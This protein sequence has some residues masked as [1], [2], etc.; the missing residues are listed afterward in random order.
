MAAIDVRGWATEQHEL[1]AMLRPAFLLLGSQVVGAV[2]A[3]SLA[4]AELAAL[5]SFAAYLDMRLIARGVDDAA[6]ANALTTAGLQHGSGT[7]MSP[8]LVL[9]GKSAAPGDMVAGPSWFRQHEPRRLAARDRL[10]VTL[11]QLVRPPTGEPSNSN[12]DVFARTLGEAAHVLQA[13]HDSGHI[14]DVLAD[15]LQRVIPMT[16]L[17]IFEA[18]WDSDCLIPRVLAGADAVKL[19]KVSLPM[20]CGIT[21]WAFARGLPYNCG[22]YDHAPSGQHHSRDGGR[23]VTGVAV[24]SAP[25]CW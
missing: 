19:S 12:T 7:Y 8:P 21:G 17:A 22:P 25:D 23:A 24:G 11:S 10:P 9:D 6:I 14:L 2:T 5:I 20:S 15:L 16:G 13:E 1:V 4:G 3:S 18:D